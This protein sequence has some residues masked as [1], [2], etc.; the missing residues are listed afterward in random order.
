M[1][2]L[3]VAIV[4]FV[5]LLAVSRPSEEQVRWILTSLSRLFH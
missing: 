4:D 1:L 5:E 2:M 3:A